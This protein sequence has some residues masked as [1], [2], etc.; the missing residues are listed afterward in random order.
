MICKHSSAL[1]LRSLASL[2]QTHNNHFKQNEL[3]LAKINLDTNSGGW[4]RIDTTLL[5]ALQDFT[6]LGLIYY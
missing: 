4:D 5:G 2:Q 3:E 1:S 6:V